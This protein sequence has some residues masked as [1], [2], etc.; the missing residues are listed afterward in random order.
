MLCEESIKPYT[1]T[2]L[3]LVFHFSEAEDYNLS[4]QENV[5]LNTQKKGEDR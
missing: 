3:Q 5:L 1:S 4:K 2:S